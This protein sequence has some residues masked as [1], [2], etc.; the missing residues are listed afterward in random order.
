MPKMSNNNIVE[1]VRERLMTFNPSHL[2]VHD[3]SHEHAGHKEAHNGMHLSIE[4]KSEQFKNMKMLAI[5]RLIYQT[6]GQLNTLGVHAL[7]IDVSTD[8]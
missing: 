1:F 6:I 3:D 2:A 7:A 8:Y 5:H 4:I